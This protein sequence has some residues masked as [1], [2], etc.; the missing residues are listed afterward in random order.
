MA[1]ENLPIYKKDF[2]PTFEDGVEKGMT[3]EVGSGSG[4]VIENGLVLTNNHVVDID[5]ADYSVITHDGTKYEAVVLHRDSENDVAV[6][7]I[8][9]YTLASTG[10]TLGDS[11]ALE[12]GQAVLSGKEV[13]IIKVLSVDILASAKSLNNLIQTD[14]P[15]ESGDSGSPLVNMYGE[16]IGINVAFS[17]DSRDVGFAIPIDIIKALLTN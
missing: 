17:D 8:R 3:K 16:V 4:F 10:A 14:I 5:G 11:S 1:T 15:I 6:L 9:S 12:V 2:D 13:G 7:K